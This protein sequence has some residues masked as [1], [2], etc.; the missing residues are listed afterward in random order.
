MISH[1][2]K[3]A[4]RNLLKYKTQSIISVLGLTIG[5]TAFAFTMSWIRYER[6]YDKHITNADRVYRVLI[7]DSTDKVVGFPSEK[8]VNKEL[9]SVSNTISGLT[10][11]I[12][13]NRTDIEALEAWV[14]SPLNT[15]EIESA[16]V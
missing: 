5:F 1:Y 12:S 11:N 14:V 4:W 13:N 2:L 10:K 3:I 6:G 15:A 9:T 7:K 8:Q 16:F